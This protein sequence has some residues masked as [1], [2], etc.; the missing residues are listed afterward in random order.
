VP[1]SSLAV[2]QSGFAIANPDIDKCFTAL[3]AMVTI[4]L[5]ATLRAIASV[6]DLHSSKTR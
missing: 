5:R 6:D 2:R 3:L 4:A 1:L